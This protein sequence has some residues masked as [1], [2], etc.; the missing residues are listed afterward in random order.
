MPP[1]MF[2]FNVYKQA[3]LNIA[4]ISWENYPK[5]GDSDRVVIICLGINRLYAYCKGVNFN[6]NIWAW[7]GF[8]SAK[9]WKSGSIYN[10]VKS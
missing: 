9:E 3:N 2:D 4:T 8:P 6:I 5:Q 10:L 7:F 1:Q